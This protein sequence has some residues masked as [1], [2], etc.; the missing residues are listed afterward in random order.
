[1]TGTA[2]LLDA[3]ERELTHLDRSDRVRRRTPRRIRDRIDRETLEHLW[4]GWGESG[5]RLSRRIARLNQEWD[6]ERALALGTAG[7]SLLGLALGAA[8]DRR[9]L[10]LPAALLGSLAL[11][12]LGGWSPPVALLRRLGIRSRQE[13]DVEKFGL[14]L[15]RGDFTA[16]LVP[17]TAVGPSSAAAS[18][19]TGRPASAAG[20]AGV[21]RG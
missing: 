10:W 19:D 9:H 17:A 15:M 8:V 1:M 20:T 4:E 5:H 7:L 13:I 21:S 6:V 18:A 16:A 14:K 12:A 3:C 11:H 2:S